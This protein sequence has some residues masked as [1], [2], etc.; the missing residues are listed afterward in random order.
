MPR[1]YIIVWAIAVH[2]VWGFALLVDPTATPAVILIGLHWVT[3][4]GVGG[5]L[6]GLLLLAVAVLA[7]VSLIA[8]ERL[9]NLISLGL[10]MPQFSLLVAA[11]FSDAQSS[12]TGVLPDGR[13]VDQIVL[14]TAL[15][16]TMVAAVLHSI[17]IVERHSAWTKR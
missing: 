8:G 1:P 10:L 17:A 16:P 14:F 5:P 15:W 12:F 11:F 7:L 9:S 3:A 2:I 6:L 4:L 13:Q